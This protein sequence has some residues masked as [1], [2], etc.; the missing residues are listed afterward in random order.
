MPVTLCQSINYTRLVASHHK[1]GPKIRH[2]YRSLSASQL[3]SHEGTTTMHSFD[4]GSNVRDAFDRQLNEHFPSNLVFSV[5]I[6]R[7]FT[8]QSIRLLH[9]TRCKARRFFQCNLNIRNA[10]SERFSFG[11]QSNRF[12]FI[13]KYGFHYYQIFNEFQFMNCILFSLN[14]TNETKCKYYCENDCNLN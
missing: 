1:N 12:D 14:S 4:L 6:L 3:V 7:S 13:G 8:L 10:Q 11:F 2:V 5:A 9:G